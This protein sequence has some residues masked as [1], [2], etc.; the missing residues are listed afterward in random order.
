[1]PIATALLDDAPMS[2]GHIPSAEQE[3]PADNFVVPRA[4]VATHARYDIDDN[5]V[6]GEDSFVSGD[7]L[8]TAFAANAD[9][10]DYNVALSGSDI[11]EVNS[12]DAEADAIHLDDRDLQH[13]QAAQAMAQPELQKLER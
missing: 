10:A 2:T 1:M 3:L 11:E 12:D 8:K 5:D 6:F 7:D 13:Q 9:E 4:K